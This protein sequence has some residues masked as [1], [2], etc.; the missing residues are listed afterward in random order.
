MYRLV[1]DK[2]SLTPN[3]EHPSFISI[4]NSHQNQNSNHQR[5]KSNSVST[6]GIF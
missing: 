1:R 5:N 4:S 2:V 3:E 6:N